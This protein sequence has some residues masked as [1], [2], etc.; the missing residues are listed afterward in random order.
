MLILILILI[1]FIILIVKTN[2]S[3]NIER[4]INSQ[5]YRIFCINME[6]SKDRWQFIKNN[7]NQQ[8]IDIQRFPAY[9]GKKINI[10]KL[11]NNNYLK[12]RNSLEYGQ[13]GCAYS[14]IKLWE[15]CLKLP[16][17]YFIILEDDTIIPNKF[18]E[19]INC[20]IENS[21]K[22]W[23]IIYLGGCYVKGK[24]VNKQFIKPTSLYGKYNL[25][26]HAYII[27]K[28]SIPKL[29]KKMKPIEYPIDNQLRQYY[30]DLD[31]YFYYKNIV[32]QNNNFKTTIA[33][34]K[35]LDKHTIFHKYSDTIEII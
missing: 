1:I 22:I 21:P 24:L 30:K 33:E 27:N 11:I 31:V 26:T 20:I 4:F 35:R 2:K 32:K 5:N 10:P 13:I 28:K 29:L 9:N 17:K 34:K 7:C 14:H 8:F 3:K 6:K 25:C 23:D 19:K 15:K 18:K 12:Y 16:Y